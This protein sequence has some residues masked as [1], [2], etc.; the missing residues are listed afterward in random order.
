MVKESFVLI[1][2]PVLFLVGCASSPINLSD[3][4]ALMQNEAIVFG[5]VEVIDEG[6]VRK[7]GAG[8]VFW[9]G[10]FKIFIMQANSSDTIEYALTGDGSFYWHLLPGRYIIAGFE[11]PGYGGF[12][13]RSGRIYAQFT[14]PKE[15]LVI[16]VGK[17]TI[18]FARGRYNVRIT[19][20]YS[21]A[22]PQLIKKFPEIRGEADRNLMQLEKPR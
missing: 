5:R 18:N 6:K 22:L 2:V 10:N 13:R 21:E 4:K 12:G 7:W 17:L 11:G 14:V 20:D 1:L 19:D 3:T 15:R 8:E 9:L 16:Y